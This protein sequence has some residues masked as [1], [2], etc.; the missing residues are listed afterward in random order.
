MSSTLHGNSAKA[1]Q[2]L[3]TL[4][5]IWGQVLAEREEW[6]RGQADDLRILDLADV[7]DQLNEA[8]PVEYLRLF[9]RLN[10]SIPVDSLGHQPRNQVAVGILKVASPEPL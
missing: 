5:G 6:V 7:Q 9:Q 3:E 2:R 4:K 10:P 8:D 1:A